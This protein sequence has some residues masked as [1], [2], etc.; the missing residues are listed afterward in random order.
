M[1]KQDPVQEALRIAVSLETVPAE[2]MVLATQHM[3]S[4]EASETLVAALL[5]AL[6]ARG[7]RPEEIASVAGVLRAQ[8]VR[9]DVPDK[10]YLLDTCGTGGTGKKLFNCST[11]AALVVAAGGVRVA[12]HGNRTA[13]RASGSADLLEQAGL[14]L[15]LTPQQAVSCLKQVGIVFLFAP[16]FHPAMR[17]LAPVRRNLGIKTIFN[18]VGPLANPAGAGLQVM[19]VHSKKMLQPMAAALNTLGSRHALVLHSQDGLDEISPSAPT[20]AVELRPDGEFRPHLIDPADFDVR[21]SL[22]QL[23]VASA[24][25][26]LD[27]VRKVLAGQPHPAADMVALN[28][29]AAFWI[30]GTCEDLKAGVERARETIKSGAGLDK[31]H[32][33]ARVSTEMAQ[34]ETP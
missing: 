34:S 22:Q 27:M 24:A 21:V 25:E 4:G 20:D 28:A 3:I 12:K 14:T 15:N 11:C 29:G 5:A 1:S 6:S 32:E 33:L 18:L 17:H 16:S 7:E 23:T 31:L 2:L 19:G 13:T 30:G 26:S 10:D 9:V 8:G